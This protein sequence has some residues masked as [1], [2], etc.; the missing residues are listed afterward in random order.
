MEIIMKSIII[1]LALIV[2]A[3]A[4]AQTAAATAEKKECC[5]CDKGEKKMACC[6]KMKG[7]TGA[8]TDPHA[9]H[10][11]AGTKNQ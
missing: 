10:D 9:G 2:A 3:P 7:D 4:A 8:S 6:D 11:I 1:G 5:C